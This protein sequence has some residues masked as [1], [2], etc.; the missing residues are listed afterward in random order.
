MGRQGIAMVGVVSGRHDQEFRLELFEDGDKEG[1]YFEIV[2]VACSRPEWSVHREPESSTIADFEE[3]S[4]SWKM[5]ILVNRHVEYCSVVEAVH[6]PISVMDVPVDYRDSRSTP[7]KSPRGSDCGVVYQTESH[8][9][10]RLR[11]M[12]GRP[13]GAENRIKFSRENRIDANN[14]ASG[15]GKGG[16]EAVSVRLRVG[17]EKRSILRGGCSKRLDVVRRVDRGDLLSCGESCCERRYLT[18]KRR[19]APLDRVDSIRRLRVSGVVFVSFEKRIR[20]HGDLLHNRHRIEIGAR[21]E[22]TVE[23]LRAR[24]I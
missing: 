24:G 8:R 18:I 21:R 12:T 5:G 23:V 20:Y 6:R 22:R 14:S 16:F 3:R 9:S 7:L 19:D 17:V 13:N 11:M 2:L 15:T 10:G 1:E 4:G